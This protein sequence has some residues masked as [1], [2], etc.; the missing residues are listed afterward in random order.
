MVLFNLTPWDFDDPPPW[1]GAWLTRD[2]DGIFRE[3]GRWELEANTQP[4]T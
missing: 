3:R 2:R 4:K 1:W